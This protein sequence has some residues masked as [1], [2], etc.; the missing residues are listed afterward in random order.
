MLAGPVI[1]HFRISMSEVQQ[2]GLADIYDLSSL[3]MGAKRLQR[4]YLRNRCV[5]SNLQNSMP[6]EPRRRAFRR[7]PC[8]K[9]WDAAIK[10]R[11]PN[12]GARRAGH[13]MNVECPPPNR[14]V[15]NRKNL[16]EACEFATLARESLASE[17]CRRQDTKLRARVFPEVHLQL[18]K[19]T[20]SIEGVADRLSTQGIGPA[21]SHS[22]T[23]ACGD[24]C[25]HGLEISCG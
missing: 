18:N 6:F 22:L 23:N 8:S 3:D 12:P 7:Q 4:T 9:H 14:R 21:L 2:S 17:P 15:M 20:D 11:S 5:D 10:H 13:T 19:W 25:A 1:C 24:Y 16:A